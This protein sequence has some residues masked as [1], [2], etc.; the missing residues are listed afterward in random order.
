MVVR[1]LLLLILIFILPVSAVLAQTDDE[2]LAIAH[3]FMA[4]L[5][6][7]DY[8]GAAAMFDSAMLAALPV[9]KLQEVWETTLPQQVGSYQQELAASVTSVNGMKVAILT[10]AF[11]KLALDARITVTADG[12][13]GGLFFAPNPNPPGGMAAAPLPDYIQPDKFTEMEI[14]VNAGSEWEL[15][16][17]LTLPKGN[18][19]FPAV[20]LVHGSGPNDRD[21]TIGPNKPFRDLAQ[22]LASNG[23]AV[24]RY[25][26]R[27]KVHGSK[28]MEAGMFTVQEETIDDALAAVELLR[29]T[30]QIDAQ[31]IFVLGH[32]LGGLLAPHIAAR[33]ENIAGIIVAAGS[34]AGELEDE[35]LRQME[36]IASLDGEV[37]PEE[38]AQLDTMREGTETLHTLTPESDHLE[39]I[40]LGAPAGYWLDLRE[41]DPIATALAVTQPM[42]VLNGGRDYQSTM[43]GF[44]AW[45]TALADRPDTTF[46]AYP[47]LNH[48]FIAGEGQIK[49]EEYLTAGH[50]AAEVIADITDWIK[51]H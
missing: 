27:T 26:K 9:D 28:M 20:V 13:I 32:S 39:T 25:D 22:G 38:Q 18:G 35:M 34:L 49:P 10:L 4:R 45:Q 21:E 29:Q 42:L 17:T 30:E 6:G 5:T 11:E 7:S 51:A 15:P 48:L 31:H 36:Y 14:I 19:P 3:E 44:T 2:V 8:A 50:V 37:T 41:Y 1:Y 40:I 46:K 16:G 24:L 47:P 23:I 12:K 43:E 33:D